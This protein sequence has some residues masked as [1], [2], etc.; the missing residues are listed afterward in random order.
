MLGHIVHMLGHGFCS[1]CFNTSCIVSL[2]IL[3]F[4]IY[5]QRLCFFDQKLVLQ[6]YESLH[7]QLQRCAWNRYKLE[8]DR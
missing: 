7:K 2:N 5:Q 1:C 4:S 3:I 8:G 6:Y